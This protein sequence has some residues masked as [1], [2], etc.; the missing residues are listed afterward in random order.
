MPAETKS[1]IAFA[2]RPADPVIA[3]LEK[4]RVR[5]LQVI[6]DAVDATLAE[7]HQA[8]DQATA[9]RDR[10]AEIAQRQRPSRA[11]PKPTI[12]DSEVA[13]IHEL[14]D[15]ATVANELHHATLDV[16]QDADVAMVGLLQTAR[17]V[18]RQQRRILPGRGLPVPPA[19]DDQPT[20]DENAR[21]RDLSGLEEDNDW[22]PDDAQGGS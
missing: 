20:E 15:L 9:A 4:W 21:P 1:M 22:W 12:L 3:E 14:A 17:E 19:E 8:F 7:L 10:V 2:R 16:E 18:E 5:N 6:N 11:K 13:L